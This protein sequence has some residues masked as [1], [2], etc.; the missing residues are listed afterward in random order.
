MQTPQEILTDLVNRFQPAAADGLSVIYQLDLTGEGGG[1]WH[2]TVADQTCTLT[3]GPAP[4]ADVT[5]GMS[6]EDWVSM[7]AKK[8]D[9][10]T[11]YFSGRLNIHGDLGLAMR[12][13]TLFGF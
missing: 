8:L 4:Q 5:I 3:D 2:L 1:T 13:Q 10:Y 7:L 11:A 6:A 12:L 9:A